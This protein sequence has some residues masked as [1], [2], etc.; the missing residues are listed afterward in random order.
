MGFQARK[1][2]KIMPGVRMTVTPRGVSASVGV[3]GARM[4]VNSKGRVTQTLGIPGTGISHQK[5]V[6]SSSGAGRPT[7]AAAAPAP[8]PTSGPKPPGLFS[9][10]WERVLFKTLAQGDF[11]SIERVAREH[12]DARATCMVLDAFL[13]AGPGKDGRA[14]AMFEELWGT[15]FDPA[16]DRFLTT[17]ASEATATVS[18]GQGVTA[19][20]P[21]NRDIIGLALAELRQEQGDL[22]GAV[23]IVESLEPSTIAAVSLADLYTAAGRWDDVIELTNGI[24]DSDDFSIFL[25]TQRGV[26]FREKGFYEA[27]RESFKASLAR[28]NQ[29]PEL[30]LQTLL[31]RAATYQREGKRAMARKDLERVLAEDPH[32]PGVAERLA[33][34]S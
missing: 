14:Q 32:F 4:S 12:P 5:T 34:S 25:L 24:S 8:A 13:A 11:D 3:K 29:P 20:M 30:K 23:A 33:E 9:P 2:F 26:A 27:A 15:G 21:L 22:A 16:A 19:T 10:K 6:V 7:N 28:R 17:Y 1:S 31:E 18:L